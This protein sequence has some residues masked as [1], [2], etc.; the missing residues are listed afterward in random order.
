MGVGEG[1][2][3]PSVQNLARR[4]VPESQRS[5]ALAFIYSGHQLGTIAS[6]LLA[7]AIISHY[8]WEAVFWIFGSLG[9]FWLLPWLKLVKNDPLEV[10]PQGGSAAGAA[11]AAAPAEP[12]RLQDIPW[13]D[14]MRNPAF[15]AIVAAQSTASVGSCLSFSWLPTFYNEVRAAPGFV[16]EGP[17]GGLGVESPRLCSSS[18]APGWRRTAL[19]FGAHCC[20]QRALRPRS[21]H[22]Q[23]LPQHA[24]ITMDA[25]S[26]PLPPHL[27]PSP[28]RCMGWMSCTPPPSPSSPL[29][30]P[31]SPPTCPAGSP[32]A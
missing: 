29:W 20:T 21:S 24:L 27:P 32:T 28:C 15:W 22:V 9:F 2:T 7:P 14:F 6:Y 8:G 26:H 17:P 11:A 18:S 19:R 31:C 5:R 12:L 25:P 1:V 3:Y 16:V 30:P 23:S 13:G 4:W 10:V